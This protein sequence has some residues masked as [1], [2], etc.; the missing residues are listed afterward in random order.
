MPGFKELILRRSVCLQIASLL[1][2]LLLFAC[3][4]PPLHPVSR[5][6]LLT[7]QIYKA[8]IIEQSPEELLAALNRI[9]EVVIEAKRNVPGKEVPVYL[10]LMATSDGIKV[11]DY[12][13]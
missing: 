10:K 3:S 1:I 9:G 13:R 8:F 7:T 2:A 11:L 12:D 6:E 4:L 5:R